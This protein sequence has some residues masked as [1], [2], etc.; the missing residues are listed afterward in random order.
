M[1][2]YSIDCKYSSDKNLKKCKITMLW[3]TR[4]KQII[5]FCYIFILM[6]DKTM[7]TQ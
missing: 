1:Y 4:R 3:R 6:N 5:Y 7:H 2:P